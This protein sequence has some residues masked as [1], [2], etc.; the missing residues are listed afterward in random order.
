MNFNTKKSKFSDKQTNFHLQS[1][2][3]ISVKH[4]LNTYT[5][6]KREKPF[7]CFSLSY[8]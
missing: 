7:F 4:L 5:L 1:N 2:F 3:E 6:T 8:H